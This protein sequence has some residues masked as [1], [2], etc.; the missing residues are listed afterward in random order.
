MADTKGSNLV[1]DVAPTLDDFFV[2]IDVTDTTMAPTGS[3]KK[4]L[5]TDILELFQD[6]L[7]S[8]TQP[9][10]AQVGTSYTLVIT[11][12]SKLIILTNASTIALTIPEDATLDFPDGSWFDIIQGGAG[13]IQ[14]IPEGGIASYQ[15]AQSGSKA[16]VQK[17][18][19]DSWHISGDI[20]EV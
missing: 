18:G 9:I 10:N 20:E 2:T 3:N 12:P 6:W 19:N 15:T 7:V 14:F 16:R 17:L 5:G 4:V 13:S 1:Q 8:R 11:D